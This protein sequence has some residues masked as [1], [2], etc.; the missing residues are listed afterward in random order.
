MNYINKILIIA[1]N[2]GLF[3]AFWFLLSVNASAAEKVDWQDDGAKTGKRLAVLDFSSK[4]I[5]LPMRDLLTEQFRQ[6]IKKLNIYALQEFG[7]LT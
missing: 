6:N 1:T 2:C 4:G 5:S 7:K 3:I